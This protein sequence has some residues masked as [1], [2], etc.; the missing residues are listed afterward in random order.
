M[1][2]ETFYWDGPSEMKVHTLPF[3]KM[4]FFRPFKIDVFIV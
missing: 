1:G 3:G 4:Q 2:N